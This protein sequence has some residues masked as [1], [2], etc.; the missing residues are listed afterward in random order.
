MQDS[1]SKGRRCSGGIHLC[2]HLRYGQRRHNKD[3]PETIYPKDMP[4]YTCVYKSPRATTAYPTGWRTIETCSTA[5]WTA[6][7]GTAPRRGHLGRTSRRS[8]ARLSSTLVAES[9]LRCQGH[10]A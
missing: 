5:S 9:S 4:D 10:W 2:R 1:V 6:I 8:G 7:S 3:T